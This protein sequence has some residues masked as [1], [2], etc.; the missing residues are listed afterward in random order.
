MPSR[1]ETTVEYPIGLAGTV[2]IKVPSGGVTIQGIDGDAVRLSSPSGRDLTDDYRIQTIDGRFEM[3][4]KPDIGLNWLGGRRFDPIHLEVPRGA[5]LRLD[6]ASG[7]VHVDGLR[8]DQEYRAASGSIK[9]TD[10]AGRVSVDHVSGDVK[11]RASGAIDLVGRTV[12]GDLNV[13]APTFGTLQFRTMSGSMRI[14]GRLVADG[15]YVVESVSGDV[16]LELDGSA[17]IEGST[18]T[19][20]IRTDLP[21][22]DSGSPGRRTIEI[23]DGGPV[24]LFKT[25]SGDLRVT[26]AAAPEPAT[27]AAAGDPAP[28][29]EGTTT[30]AAASTVAAAFAM[31][32]P[33]TPPMPPVAPEPPVPPTPPMA[34]MAPIAPESPA[35]TASIATASGEAAAPVGQAPAEATPEALA[36][37]RLA[38]LR[39]LEEG[40]IEIEAASAR[41]AEIDAEEDRARVRARTFDIGP[42]HG[43]LRWDHRA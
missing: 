21:H 23:G 38:I 28:A 31:P 5:A 29:R 25:L 22:R 35:M 37:R 40:R 41:L 7:S 1:T 34:P 10:V 32:T 2:A 6:T 15:T 18:V 12:S 24:V 8:G 43:E 42:L 9:L 4:P 3:K 19:G 33:P 16:N 13:S 36:A 14:A 39:E 30:P 26:R 27:D 11:V 17:R 20:R